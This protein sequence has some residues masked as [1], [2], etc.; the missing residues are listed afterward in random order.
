MYIDFDLYT[1]LFPEK[2]PEQV[3]Q[4]V[5]IL[6][7][8]IARGSKS[9]D[10]HSVTAQDAAEITRHRA[11]FYR[12]MGWSRPGNM[13]NIWHQSVWHRRN[14][15]FSPGIVVQDIR[16]IDALYGQ[17]DN[18]AEHVHRCRELLG[19]AA[20]SLQK[21][22][23]HS[24]R[25]AG[26]FGWDEQKVRQTIQQRPDILETS[27]KLRFFY[28]RAI[29]DHPGKLKM[30]SGAQTVIRVRDWPAR[31]VLGRVAGFGDIRR[32]KFR[33]DDLRTMFLYNLN[34]A[35]YQRK[36]GARVLHAY[37][38]YDPVKNMELL[39]N[40]YPNLRQYHPA[41]MREWEAKK[42]S[43]FKG[44]IEPDAPWLR[45]AA[46]PDKEIDFEKL[47]NS[48]KLGS[49]RLTANAPHAQVVKAETIAARKDFI[50]ALGWFDPK[51]E[52]HS[53]ACQLA[54]SKK[55][56]WPTPKR[57]IDAVNILGKYTDDPLYCMKVSPKGAF[58][59]QP[60]K[61]EEKLIAITEAFAGAPDLKV[62]ISKH[63]TKSI[64]TI[65]EQGKQYRERHGLVA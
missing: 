52:M 25:L 20:A 26:V 38:R 60:E 12:W 28:A 16:F 22:Y 41:A 56:A 43:Q 9:Q 50:T 53:F 61:L 49:R 35:R 15:D 58:V 31:D 51:H 55:L 23:D 29:A 59:G 14:R 8:A 21:D 30:D 18:L 5:P 44:E 42:A 4:I 40:H 45:I 13:M 1:R 63:V 32:R 11:T 34:K 47:T 24:V 2:T 37:F 64:A 10:K 65:H 48:A 36:V 46:L 3:A 57:I 62:L 33:K 7:D 6:N 19:C 39:E 17:D 27:A 54:E